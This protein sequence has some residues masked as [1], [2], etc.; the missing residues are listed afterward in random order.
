MCLAQKDLPCVRWPHGAQ[1]CLKMT[2]CRKS[3]GSA[4]AA[5]VYISHSDRVTYRNS[6]DT[7]ALGRKF[8]VLESAW[9]ARDEPS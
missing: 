6:E 9:I 2:Q 1:P 3:P 5:L 8:A 4:H 7:R